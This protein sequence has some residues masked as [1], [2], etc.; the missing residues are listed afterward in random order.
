MYIFNNHFSSVALI[1]PSGANTECI[2]HIVKVLLIWIMEWNV[3]CNFDKYLQSTLCLNP[4][5]GQ[6]NNL[7]HQKWKKYSKLPTILSQFDQTLNRNPKIQQK[8]SVQP[9]NIHLIQFL[10]LYTVAIW[11]V[12]HV[13]LHYSL[14]G[15]VWLHLNLDANR[16]CTASL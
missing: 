6:T 11:K 10:H 13:C 7:P 9:R 16:C 2:F 8:V 4:E 3:L 5:Y 1:A 15:K 12:F 14:C